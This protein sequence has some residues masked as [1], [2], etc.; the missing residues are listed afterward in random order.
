[1]RAFGSA[2]LIFSDYARAA[3]RLSALMELPVIYIFT[4][5]SIGVGEDGPT[6]QPIEQLASLRA[7]PGLIVLRPADA[8]EVVEAWK[9][10]MK[11]HHEP[12]VLILTRQA[13]PTLD[14]SKY[15]PASGVAQGAYILADARWQARRVLLATGS[16]VALCLEAY[17]QLKAKGIKARVVSM[18]SWELFEQ[19]DQPTATACC[20]RR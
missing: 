18:P 6:H 13:V 17:E 1:M 5:D 12:V 14:R 11:L 7:I 19:Q 16:E 9:V 2:F 3:I 4:H 8:N 20:R 15:A 10:I